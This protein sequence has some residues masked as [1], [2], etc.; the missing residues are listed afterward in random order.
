MARGPS[1]RP[2]RPH[3]PGSRLEGRGTGP[4]PQGRDAP[5]RLP[6]PSAGRGRPGGT[7]QRAGRAE[8]ALRPFVPDTIIYGRN[9]VR[10]ALRSGRRRVR[11]LWMLYGRPGEALE[12]ELRRWTAE[13]GLD[14]PAIRQV[15]GEELERRAGSAEHQGVVAEAD[16]YPYAEPEDVLSGW[17]LVVA[18]D[19]VQDPHNLGAVIRTADAAGAAVVIPRHRAA[20]VTPAAVKASAGAAEHV[21]VA[22]VRNL[23]DFL[24][25]AKGR[26]FWVYGAAAEALAAYD[27]QDYRRPAVFVLGSEGQGLSRRVAEACD[28]LVSVPLHGQVD[29]LNVS[30]ATGVL[31]FE[32][33][34]QRAAGEAD[35]KAGGREGG[36]P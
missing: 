2:R 26:S 28:V 21:P 4:R 1:K 7:E 9:P 3:L 12:E 31:L 20:A 11:Q 32:A 29:S 25:A 36:R 18:L 19:R 13:R 30:V 24:A 14:L 34:R 23:T 8:E 16:P 27:S 6:S 10:E 17:D 35:R 22:Q 33:R 5:S 15:T